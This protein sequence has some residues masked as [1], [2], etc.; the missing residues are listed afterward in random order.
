MRTRRRRKGLT[1]SLL[2][3]ALVLAQGMWLVPD[4]DLAD[5]LG[6]E[7]V[8]LA[9]AAVVLA[10]QHTAELETVADE[11]RGVAASVPTRGI[12]VFPA[13]M[14]D[15]VGLV[16]RTTDSLRILCD[17]PAHGAFSN[18][19]AFREYW[20]RLRHLQVDGVAINCTFLD[21]SE[22][23]KMHRAQIQSDAD[24]WSAWQQ[25]NQANCVAFDQF[26]REMAVTPTRPASRGD[27]VAA[28]AATPDAYVS[29]MMAINDAV[30]REFNHHM[31]VEWLSFKDP[32]HE[33]PSVYF[34]LRDEDQEAVFVIVPV[35]GIGV[36]DFA[37]FHTR[38]P[39]LIRALHNVFQHRQRR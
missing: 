39:E 34:W 6:F 29:S 3:L 19:A 32:L 24:D 15:V 16:S 20:R 9:V 33:G 1:Y 21:R 22:R 26:A 5:T 2:L 13:Y 8:I 27:A 30:A 38:E 28:W 10:V 31:R 36:R 17:T 12:G 18:T 11:L 37:G 25:R 35:R 23:E 7:A 4:L 14:T